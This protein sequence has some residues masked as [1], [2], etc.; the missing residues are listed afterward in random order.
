MKK[1]VMLIGVAVMLIGSED[2]LPL[3]VDTYHGDIV[4]YY[5]NQDTN[6]VKAVINESVF[7]VLWD[8][9]IKG[10]QLEEL[11]CKDFNQWSK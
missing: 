1:L 6:I 8:R 7:K 2:L 3:K 11:K 4:H 5:C 10:N 9:D